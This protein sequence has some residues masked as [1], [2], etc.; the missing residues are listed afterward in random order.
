VIEEKWRHGEVSRKWYEERLHTLE[1]EMIGDNVRRSRLTSE[2][3]LLGVLRHH[4]AA[5][6][7][8]R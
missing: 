4:I 1:N 3:T 6:V 5:L 2:Y 8:A 7:A